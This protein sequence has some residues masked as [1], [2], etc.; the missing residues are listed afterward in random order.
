MLRLAAGRNELLLHIEELCE[1]DTIWFVELPGRDARPARL[2]VP[3]PGGAALLDASA[4]ASRQ[5]ARLDREAYVASRCGCCCPSRPIRPLTFRLSGVGAGNAI[6]AIAER[7]RRGG[8]R[9]KPRSAAARAFRRAIIEL[10]LVVRGRRHAVCRKLAAGFADPALEP[11]PAADPA[12]RRR[13][14]LEYVARHGGPQIGRALALA[15]IGGDPATCAAIVDDTLE[16]IERREDC[17]DFWIPPLLFCC[18][19]PQACR[20]GLRERA[21]QAILGYRYWIDEPGNDVMWFW[22]E[23]HALCFHAAQYLAGQAFPGRRVRQFRPDRPRAGRRSAGERLDA[24]VRRH[25]GQR[26]H[27]VE[28]ARLLPD[29]LPSAS[30]RCTSWRPMPPIREAAGRCL[31]RLFMMTALSTLDGI[32]SSTQG[33]SYDRDL[34]FPALTETRPSPG[35]SGARAP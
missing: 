6:P 24:L 27:R 1:R 31:D 23:N 12:G 32:P 9:W 33:R 5:G 3:A 25:R 17:S 16:R 4:P 35:S 21:R 18:A 14:A 22:S 13:Q 2:A 29:R 26:L 7:A 28:L 8:R 30:W 34:K 11:Q 10:G 20:A 19:V 15:A